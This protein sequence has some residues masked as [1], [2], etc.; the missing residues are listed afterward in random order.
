M[1]WSHIT[2]GRFDIQFL[3][4]QFFVGQN[5]PECRNLF[6]CYIHNPQLRNSLGYLITN[7]LHTAFPVGNLALAAIFL[8]KICQKPR[9]HVARVGR[10]GKFPFLRI[11]CQRVNKTHMI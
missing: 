1:I 6:L 2:T 7:L 8:I 5:M 10:N 11:F 9:N 4:R 3:K